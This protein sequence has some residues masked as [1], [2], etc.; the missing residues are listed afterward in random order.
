MRW[1]RIG[2]LVVLAVVGVLWALVGLRGALA[3]LAV[4]ILTIPTMLTSFWPVWT[5]A[6]VG[7]IVALGQRRYKP[8][9]I[10]L[11][12]VPV[13]SMTIV[14]AVFLQGGFSTLR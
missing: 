11:G 9:W 8:L 3:L 14:I 13:L 5:P 6:V 2:G 4:G 1:L 10:G 12:F 7:A